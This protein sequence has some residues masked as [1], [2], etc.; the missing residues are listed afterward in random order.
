MKSKFLKTLIYLPNNFSS[1]AFRKVR[2]FFNIRKLNFVIITENNSLVNDEKNGKVQS[3]I[4]S[5]NVNSFNYN[6]LL[7]IGGNSDFTKKAV[8]S[9]IIQKFRNSNSKIIAIQNG[10]FEMVNN[11]NISKMQISAEIY[12]FDYFSIRNFIPIDKCIVEYEKIVTI[13]NL[14]ALNEFL[15]TQFERK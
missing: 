14:S 13:R 10:I 5:N 1:E 4:N 7:I 11:L 3:E 9:E 6:A 15:E 8:L 12:D 2:N